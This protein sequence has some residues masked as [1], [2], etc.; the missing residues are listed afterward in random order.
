MRQFL[1]KWSRTPAPPRPAADR[2]P[3]K[4]HLAIEALEIRLAPVVGA[5][6]VP[7][8][9]PTGA[10]L[11][12]VVLV[13]NDPAQLCTG[14]LLPTGRHILTAAHCVDLD[15]NHLPDLPNH[16]TV[17]FELSGDKFISYDVPDADVIIHPGWDGALKHGN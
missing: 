12:G 9:V 16:T 17:N 2:R 14:S 5:A 1:K 7:V 11:D 6:A 4:A 10:G 13:K 8:P 3:R 15:G